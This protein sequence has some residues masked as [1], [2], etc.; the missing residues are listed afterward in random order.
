MVRDVVAHLT[1]QELGL[2]A[3]I[4][5]LIRGPTTR[6][7][8]DDQ[9]R[10]P[11]GRHD[12]DRSDDRGNLGHVGSP[13]TTSASPV[14]RPS[15]TSSCMG[16]TLLFRSIGRTHAVESGLGG[17]HLC[18]DLR[19]ALPREEEI[20]RIPDRCNRHAMGCRRRPKSRGP[21]GGH[22][23]PADWASARTASSLRRR[24]PALHARLATACL[25]NE[26]WR[27]FRRAAD[28]R[29]ILALAAWPR[30]HVD[31]SRSGETRAVAARSDWSA[32]QPRTG[33]GLQCTSIRG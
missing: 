29:S 23:A 20:R 21:D 10:R 25:G 15:S 27:T 8:P 12:V 7:E 33:P 19:L 26:R 2:F 14:A 11:L 4:G 16:K 24:C 18:L 3:A 31:A 32:R 17:R 1:S 22:P 6:H 28:I 13:K 9:R 30:C 5:I